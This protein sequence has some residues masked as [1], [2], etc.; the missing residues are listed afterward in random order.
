MRGEG[1]GGGGRGWGGERQMEDAA[2]ALNSVYHTADV[3]REHQHEVR[4]VRG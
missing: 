1:G 2:F 4:G 3:Q